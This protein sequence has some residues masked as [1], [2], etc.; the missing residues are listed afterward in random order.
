VPRR[1]NDFQ[2]LVLRIYSALGGAN[3]SVEE[4]VLL[5]EKNSRVK[6]EIDVLVTSNVAGHSV[7]VAVEA[8]DHSARQDITWVDGLIGKY[9]NLD[10]QKVVAIS[11]TGFSTTA[12]EK[13]KQHNIEL[14][15]LEEAKVVNWEDR[16]GPSAF[17]F[18]GFRNRPMRIGLRRDRADQLLIMYTFEGDLEPGCDV[19]PSV[20][21]FFLEIWQ[22]HMAHTAGQKISDHVFSDWG[23]I[24]TGPNTPRYWEIT[25][26]Y[27][28]PRT[29]HIDASHSI[30]FDE[31]IWGI[32]TKYAADTISPTN[33]RIGDKA[34]TTAS[35]L[36][37]QGKPVHITLV[38]DEAGKYLGANV[39]TH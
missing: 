26:K 21:E 36:D 31:I 7:R 30:T 14:I 15:T 4:S 20:A 17:Q 33:W 2:K 12:A 8:R 23:R 16:L 22:M 5:P 18:F 38:T 29:I 39:E 25:E 3:S 1:S 27:N 11:H 9:A 28:A 35:A 24:S 34:V 32:G 19:N 10:V 6:R 37:D 13:A